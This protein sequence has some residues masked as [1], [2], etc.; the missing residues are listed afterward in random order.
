VEASWE[1]LSAAA[2]G[3]AAAVLFGLGTVM[4]KKKPI[5]MPPAASVAWQA[6]LGMV[7]VVALAA[8]EHADF[9][10]VTAGG[11]VSVAFIACIPMTVAY[12][13]WFRALR[14]VSASTASTTVLISPVVGVIGSGVLLGE[15][16]GPRQII[17]LV[18][19]L[20]GVALAARG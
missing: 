20:T 19:T 11:W 13:A 9:G 7:I 6:M 3:L 17:A 8:F 14:T 1:K 12:L 18:M 4:A 10:R 15:V 5:R 16:F 2:M